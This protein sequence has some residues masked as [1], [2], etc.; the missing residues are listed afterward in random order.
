MSKGH[1]KK[2]STLRLDIVEL[3]E[4]IFRVLRILQ[5]NRHSDAKYSYRRKCVC[6]GMFLIFHILGLIHDLQEI[7]KN[8]ITITL[9]L[10]TAVFQLCCKIFVLSTSPEKVR[11]L[12]DWMRNLKEDSSWAHLGPFVEDY[13]HVN[14][15]YTR[16]AHK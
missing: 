3:Q 8:K 4:K 2:L 11:E 16:V 6:S 5:C 7:E 1:F 9:I 12:I 10:F 14:L 15:K 13:L